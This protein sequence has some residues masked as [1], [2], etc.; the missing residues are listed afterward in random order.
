MLIGSQA[1]VMGLYALLGIMNP[2]VCTMS[3]FAESVKFYV[4]V[5]GQ[6]VTLTFDTHVASFTHL[7]DCKYKI[8]VHRQQK[9]QKK[10]STFSH[11]KAYATRSDLDVN[12]VKIK[13]VII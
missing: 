13:Q 9:F 1:H 6:G 3:L 8:K 10:K 2:G 11:T 5:G 4:K 12:W 7:V